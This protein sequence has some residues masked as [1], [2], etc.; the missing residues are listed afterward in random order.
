MTLAIV[1]IVIVLASLS[2]NWLSPWS[3]T[4]LASNWG[5]MDDMLH[6][7]LIITGVA[8]T[9]V[10][11]FVAYAVIRFRHREGARAHYEPENK[12]LEWWLIG[13]T[14]LGIVAMLT[15]GLFVYLDFVR[16]PASAGVVEIV[17]QQWQWS[18][19][20][21]GADGKLGTSGA[22]FVSVDNPFG[23]NPDDAAGQDDVLIQGGEL[24]LAKDRPVKV[25]LRS[26]DVLHNFY[27]PQFR[28]KMDLVP[29]M[30]SHFWFTPT[31]LGSFEILCAELCGTG[32]YAMRGKVAVVD[33]TAFD[34][35]LG[36]QPTFAQQLA[37][38]HTA[39]DSGDVLAAEGRKLVN[40]QGCIACHSDDGSRRVGPTWKDLYGHQV[41]LADGST[42]TVDDAYIE[43]SIANP[44]AK[45]VR[46]FLPVM[47]PYKF[48]ADEMKA[49]IA[50]IRSLA[51]APG[52]AAEPAT[53]AGAEPGAQAGGDAAAQGRALAQ[54]R[55]C[56][57]CHSTDGSKMVGPTWQGLFGHRVTLADGSTITAD[58]KY[59]EES[60]TAPNAKVV[61]GYPPAM[62]PTPLQPAE[63][64]A[65]VAYIKSLPAGH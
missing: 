40:E 30:V 57:A 2:F 56:V 28:A 29:G 65:L 17:G 61:Q 52:A 10:T 21:P 26:K 15:P 45:V 60:I 19:R 55:G 31:R 38:A 41:T 13:L 11:F 24:Q 22:H 14:T 5:R 53:P 27:V 50:Y 23:L 16:V 43:E 44:S 7:T 20:F 3:F 49:V 62:P 4:E 8:F 54:S 32:H 58:E 18:F 51:A 47:Q 35:W 37:R 33:G 12:K 42:L 39:A 9:L 64:A 48:S 46:D 6:I 63:V 34:R 36:A 25:L 1:L 59:L